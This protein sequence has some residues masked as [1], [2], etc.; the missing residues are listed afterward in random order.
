MDEITRP[1][2]PFIAII[3]VINEITRRIQIIKKSRFIGHQPEFIEI[4]AMPHFFQFFIE[5]FSVGDFHRG[6][7][8]FAN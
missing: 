2:Q 4:K 3:V 7:P 8:I 1:S 5:W 6:D